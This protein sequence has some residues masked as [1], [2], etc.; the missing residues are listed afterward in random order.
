LVVPHGP[1]DAR[2]GN[3]FGAAADCFAYPTLAFGEL[4]TVWVATLRR[5]TTW[6][7]HDRSYTFELFIDR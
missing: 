1:P 3:G 2:E 4:D 6:N 7:G 5:Q